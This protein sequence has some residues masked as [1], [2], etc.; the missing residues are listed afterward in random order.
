MILKPLVALAKVKWN[1]PPYLVCLSFQN[2]SHDFYR[3]GLEDSINIAVIHLAP[4][5]AWG[6]TVARMCQQ[7]EMSWDAD[8]RENHELVTAK[9][10]VEKTGSQEFHEG[11]KKMFSLKNN[12][13]FKWKNLWK[14]AGKYSEEKC[15]SQRDVWLY[16]K[17][18]GGLQEATKISYIYSMKSWG[19]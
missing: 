18:H 15:R 17:E 3:P 7:D 2:S 1:V 9:I 5:H 12:C 6:S 19:I 10:L 4:K 14:R 11:I 16:G 13:H 8:S